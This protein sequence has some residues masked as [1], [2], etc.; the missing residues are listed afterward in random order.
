MNNAEMAA[1]YASLPP[2]AN[3][4]IALIN[5]DT[6]FVEEI[7]VDKQQPEFASYKG[8]IPEGIPCIIQKY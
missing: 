3:A 4:T 2:A 7:R 8:E 1:Y 6:E 5:A